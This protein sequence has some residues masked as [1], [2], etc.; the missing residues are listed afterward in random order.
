MIYELLHM[1]L[2]GFAYA[3]EPER[4]Q[5]VSEGQIVFLGNHRQ[6]RLVLDDERWH[7]NC[8][9]YAPT[10]VLSWGPVCEHVIAVERILDPR[11]QL[12]PATL[13]VAY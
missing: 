11:R 4:M 3:T 6:H 5:V 2:K 7:C 9:R 12:S 13:P 8:E 1:R 10:A